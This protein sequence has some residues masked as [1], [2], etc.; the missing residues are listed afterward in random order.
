MLRAGVAIKDIKDAYQSQVMPPVIT[1]GR[2]I[3]SDPGSVHAPSVSSFPIPSQPPQ[4][5]HCRHH[6][7]P[8]P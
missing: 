1:S 7:M 6:E 8:L 2:W 4:C 3:P 5:L